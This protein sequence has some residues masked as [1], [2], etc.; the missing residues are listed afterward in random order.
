ME[1]FFCSTQH[2]NVELSYMQ[3]IIFWLYPSTD[4]HFPNTG[5][6][7]SLCKNSW[8]Y[9]ISPVARPIFLHLNLPFL[10]VFNSGCQ[11]V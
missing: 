6:Y 3:C 7:W 5:E 8:I 11:H 10:H 1:V 2:H 4:F 9:A